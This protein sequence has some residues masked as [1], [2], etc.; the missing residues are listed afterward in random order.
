MGM[1]QRPKIDLPDDIVDFNINTGCTITID[2]WRHDKI[3]NWIWLFTN[4]QDSGGLLLKIHTRHV[5]PL[6]IILFFTFY[7][8]LNV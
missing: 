1:K 7:V 8:I 2:E 5:H 6:K 3:S 4:C